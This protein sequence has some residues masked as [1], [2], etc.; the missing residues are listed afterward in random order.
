MARQRTLHPNFFVDEKVVQVS[1][2]A[3]LM[4]Q[5]LWCLADREGR[6]ERKPLKLKMQL[7]P[8]D[9]V[10]GEHLIAE[11][12]VVGLVTKYEVDGHAYIF[13]P[14]FSRHQHVHPKEVPSKLPS[15]QSPGQDVKHEAKAQAFGHG[16]GVEPGQMAHETG[17]S[18]AGP[19]GTSDTAGPSWELLP[20]PRKRSAPKPPA[21]K[22][23]PDPR[24]APLVKVFTDV[25]RR[26]RGTEYPFNGGR[27]AQLVTKLLARKPGDTAPELW[28]IKLAAAWDRALDSR[29]PVVSTL[30]K[31]ER[32]LPSFLGAGPPA[33]PTPLEKLQDQT[34]PR[35][36]ATGEL[37]WPTGDHH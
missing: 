4:F 31:F 21:T 29:F 34:K 24:H 17:G 2:F 12:E 6:L 10:D 7:F 25:F 11:L 23:P 8:A 22:A 32:D 30:E 27:D 16:T 37:Q 19:S 14:G 5:G 13:I 33:P 26:K 3:R 36:H 20:A 1:A 15:P 9:A 28:P 35:P 18:R